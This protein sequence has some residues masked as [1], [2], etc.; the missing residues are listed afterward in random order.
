MP[1]N[2][3]IMLGS[4]S[5]HAIPKTHHIGPPKRPSPDAQLMHPV[6]V[7]GVTFCCPDRWRSGTLREGFARVVTGAGAMGCVPAIFGFK[8]PMLSAGPCAFATFV[9]LRR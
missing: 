3:Q 1:C 7:L 4:A 2:R 8:S 5:P 6:C 9:S